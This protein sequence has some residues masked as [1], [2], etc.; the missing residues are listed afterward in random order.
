[1]SEVFSCILRDLEG[2]GVTLH[3]LMRTSRRELFLDAPDGLGHEGEG[4][5]APWIRY[6]A[7]MK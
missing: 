7:H 1:M 4:G 2:K 5:A 3:T 6:G